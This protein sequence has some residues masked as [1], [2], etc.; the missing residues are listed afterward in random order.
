MN[1]RNPIYCEN[2]WIDCEINHPEYGWIPFTCDPDDK[3]ALFDAAALFEEMKPHAA[4]YVPPPPPTDEELAAAAREERNALLAESDWTQLPDARSAMG[5]EK[6]EEWDT[7]RQAL[8][9]VPEQSG[10]PRD[11]IWPVKPE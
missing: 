7:Y 8:R 1:Y 11:I 9:D 3:G 4:P 5:P 6:A 2:G 10:F